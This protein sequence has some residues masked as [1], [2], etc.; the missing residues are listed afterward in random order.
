[1]TGIIDDTE[2]RVRRPAAGRKDRNTFISGKSK[3]NAV[4]TVVVQDGDGRVL[5]CSPTKPGSCA[6]T[7]HARQPGL[8][9]LLVDGP[10]VEVLADAATRA[11][12]RRPA[13]RW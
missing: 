7:T 12:A 2:I 4:K 3:Q 10:A 8:V 9:K 13:V 1:M 11:S 5:F 6:D